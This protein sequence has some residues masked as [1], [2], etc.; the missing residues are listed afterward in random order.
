MTGRRCVIYSPQVEWTDEYYSGGVCLENP[1]MGILS[2][3]LTDFGVEVTIR[4]GNMEEFSLH[5]EV[6]ED[7]RGAF[8]LLISAD[9]SCIFGLCSWLQDVLLCFVGLTVIIGDVAASLAWEDVL[10]K[11]PRS[12]YVCVGDGIMPLRTWAKAGFYAPALRQIP[13]IASMSHDGQLVFRMPSRSQT[14]C[15]GMPFMDRQIFIRHRHPRIDTLVVIGSMGCPGAC[16]FC[17]RPAIAEACRMPAWQGRSMPDIRQELDYLH[18]QYGISR[19]FF[20]DDNFLGPTSYAGQRADSF[21]QTFDASGYRL[22][23]AARADVVCALGDDRLLAMRSA[24]I[25]RVF[26]G[27]ESFSDDALR[28]FSKGYDAQTNL[29]AI[30][31]L[32]S[33]GILVHCGFINFYPGITPEVMRENA[34]GLLRS[35]Q[36]A[37][38]RHFCSILHYAPGTN[39]CSVAFSGNSQRSLLTFASCVPDLDRKTQALLLELSHLYATLR[40]GDMLLEETSYLLSHRAHVDRDNSSTLAAIKAYGNIRTIMAQQNYDLFT[41]VVEGHNLGNVTLWHHE[42]MRCLKKL[43]KCLQE[44]PASSQ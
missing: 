37:Y 9:S 7:L 29:D 19:F 8:C 1:G 2:A 31:K 39:W 15:D 28:I 36:G 25:E 11:M 18:E 32:E 4:D 33:A 21:I 20:F 41:R 24:G 10:R 23:I 27:V 22:R 30:H 3:V 26:L 17:T 42:R 35:L 43:R 38:F 40:E 5:S 13:G 34:L 12:V 16:S 6:T 44:C 14:L